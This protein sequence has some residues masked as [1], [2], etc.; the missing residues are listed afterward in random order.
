MQDEVGFGL[1]SRIVTLLDRYRTLSLDELLKETPATEDETIARDI[2]SLL[3]SQ[4]LT[5]QT[6]ETGITEGLLAIAGKDIEPPQYVKRTDFEV[7]YNHYSR[8]TSEQKFP[9]L[10]ENPEYFTRAMNVFFAYLHAKGIAVKHVDLSQSPVTDS[11][12]LP[13]ETVTAWFWRT[14][15]T[16]K[17]FRGS[18]LL[19]ALNVSDNYEQ[20]Q[21][22]VDLTT[23]PVLESFAGQRIDI[24]NVIVNKVLKAL[25]LG[26]TQC[27]DIPVPKDLEKYT[28]GEKFT[29][30]AYTSHLRFFGAD[31]CSVAELPRVRKLYA[32]NARIPNEI[33]FGV[34]ELDV[35]GQKD[36]TDLIVSETV[37]TFIFNPAT[38]RN[39]EAF[40]DRL[41]EHLKPQFG[42]T[43]NEY[44]EDMGKEKAFREGWEFLW[45]PVPEDHSGFCPILENEFSIFSVYN[46]QHKERYEVRGKAPVS[47]I[48]NSRIAEILMAHGVDEEH[49][50]LLASQDE[51]VDGIPAERSK[52][53]VYVMK[54][55]DGKIRV[56]K[57][58]ENQE[59][60]DI[61][62][63]VLYHFSRDP[64][65]QLYV[66]H[67]ELDA[68]SRV[69]VGDE[70]R[71]VTVQS[72][73]SDAKADA[74]LHGTKQD[75]MQYLT[76]WMRI[77]ARLHVY[78][79]EIMDELGNYH[80]AARLLRERSEDRIIV[81]SHIIPLVHDY[82]LRRAL[83]DIGIE[84]GHEFIHQDL[85]KRHMKGKGGYRTIDWGNA[86]RGKCL[87]DIVRGIS[88][89]TIQRHNITEGDEKTLLWSYLTK[90]NEITKGSAP[91]RLA[92]SRL[93]VEHA[94]NTLTALKL[95]Y[96]PEYCGYH[97]SKGE[98]TSTVKYFI[99]QIPLLERK[100]LA[101]KLVA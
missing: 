42:R 101:L 10:A 7:K 92:V 20:I 79:T 46:R 71:Y 30:K 77:L 65:L 64:R 11:I 41:P 68:P 2:A 99:S 59:E 84:E 19:K 62:A 14:H 35:W 47:N 45:K 78:G 89:E 51:I 93:E 97:I 73:V 5:A 91:L 95:A 48:C 49:A 60:A 32:F 75:V 16:N 88:D 15:I 96:Y 55:A 23:Y 29:G 31:N 43:I 26:C 52:N 69:H 74:L 3:V 37:E 25:Y 13:E 53:L 22:T 72:F 18:G 70:P 86:G 12:E 1:D 56:V 61:E 28:P 8:S 58:V 87:V 17:F 6:W 54:Y 85:E 98:I 36:I 63:L 83:M 24:E 38:I 21:G 82:G 34:R 4:V 39:P 66:A 40:Y 94:H 67:S 50:K 100:V 9:T 57:F 44:I 90:K 27:G 33:P 76:N 81:A 80:P